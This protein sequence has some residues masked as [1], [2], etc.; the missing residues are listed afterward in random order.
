MQVGEVGPESPKPDFR[1]TTRET[2]NSFI[3]Q[4]LGVGLNFWGALYFNYYIIKSPD[5]ASLISK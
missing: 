4:V 1:G 2:F 3:L 5:T